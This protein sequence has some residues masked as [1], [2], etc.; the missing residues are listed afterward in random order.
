[1]AGKA[2]GRGGGAG[3]D[4]ESWPLCIVDDTTGEVVAQVRRETVYSPAGA[5]IGARI[6]DAVTGDMVDVPA[7]THLAVCLG[8]ECSE[9]VLCD[10]GVVVLEGASG[11]L[12]DGTG[13]NLTAGDPEAGPW[14]VDGISG[15]PAVGFTAPV[16]VRFS[17]RL[18]GPGTCLV[19]PEG[20]EPVDLAPHHV[21]TPAT[22][23]LCWP[24]AT[25]G[26]PA[27]VSVFETAGP[28]EALV[29]DTASAVLG[30][31]HV[32][33]ITVLGDGRPFLRTLCRN[34]E[35]VTATDTDLDGTT[36][37]TPVG[38]VGA[39]GAADGGTCLPP[40]QFCFSSTSTVDRPGRVYEAALPIAQGFGIEAIL[41]DLVEY[42]AP[43]VWGVNDPTG[44]QFAADLQAV[45]QAR[46]PAATVTVTPP[47]I[48]GTCGAPEIFTVRI[49]C[50]A[51]DEQPPALVQ[52]RYN[53][54]RDLIQNP[55]FITTP[56][57]PNSGP[58]YLRRVDAGGTLNCTS[59]AGRGWETNDV[60][61]MYEY[62]GYAN[63]P[64]GISALNASKNTT[65]TP[66]ATPILEINAYGSGGG[67]PGTIW[68]T[69]QVTAA[70]TFNIRVTVGARTL[71][72][73]QIAVKLSTGD[74]DAAGTGDLID[75]VLNAQRVTNE[76]GGAPGPWTTYTNSLVLNPGTYT[77]AFTGPSGQGAAGGL[78]TDMRV[79][80]DI[81]GQLLNFATDDDE[82]IVSGAVTS[83]V[84]QWWQAQCA[85][86]EIVSWRR[87]ADG[88]ALTNAEFWAQVPAPSCCTG[89]GSGGG[90][91][92]AG[93]LVNSYPVCALVSGVRQ[94]LQRVVIADQAGGVI[95]DQFIGPDGTAVAPDSWEPG[96][97]ADPT[98]DAEV[99]VLCD[100]AGP[101]LRRYA[102]SEGLVVAVDTALDGVTPY[103][104]V[105]E[106][107]T[108][109]GGE[110]SA[111][112]PAAHVLEACRWDD[113]DDDG[114]ADTAYVELLSVDPITGELTPIGTYTED[115]SAPYTP[116]SPAP[117]PDD[118][119]PD[120]VVVIRAGRVDLAPGQTWDAAT[121]AGLQSVTATAW[122]GPAQ[123]TT[124]DGPSVLHAG[125]TVTWSTGRDSD[126]YLAAPL[127]VAAQA[128]PVTVTYTRAT[129]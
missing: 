70:G 42:A 43:V 45:T 28:V 64:P 23:R 52:Y 8:A 129:T 71:P 119:G 82:C 107:G 69:F 37:Y 65:P 66:R 116:T 100:E 123:V 11:T 118:P 39:C 111:A 114:V 22:R 30:V 48:T 12:P 19:I 106:V 36:P 26:A 120:P 74:V 115:L 41:I 40:Q 109:A 51:L 24:L 17:A 128:S 126:A 91:S 108:C 7:G 34:G 4:V 9:L 104:A 13:W 89:D 83:T 97:C 46:F 50:L 59:V 85:G 14:Y 102:V 33:L 31:H 117:E 18:D 49:E 73:E 122:D 5:A 1:M 79:Y 80:Q 57:T 110:S 72:V 25:P 94:T 67:A 47:G 78:F 16:R 81:P 62:W 68:Q 121:V 10:D 54:G 63:N 95:S 124:E 60:N 56:P 101:F 92:S 96:A 103:V 75:T 86:G 6:V 27:D 87:L 2:C 38:Q 58:N 88:L 29:W 3:V 90:S 61:Q 127:L 76:G 125:E 84:C 112:P 53:A 35:S 44:D 77:L 99:V 21:W 20:A 105:G 55:G 113:T 32:G 15:V 98:P 93:N